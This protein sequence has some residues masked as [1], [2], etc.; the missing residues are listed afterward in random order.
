MKFKKTY[1]LILLLFF[2]SNIIAQNDFFIDVEASN[3][4]IKFLEKIETFSEEKLEEFTI[5]ENANVPLTI[6]EKKLHLDLKRKNKKLKLPSY[7]IYF[8]STYSY[9]TLTIL[10]ISRNYDKKLYSRTKLNDKTNLW[11][12]PL[13]EYQSM[14]S[15]KEY[16]NLVKIIYQLFNTHFLEHNLTTK[17]N[18]I[19][20][21][22]TKEYKLLAYSFDLFTCSEVPLFKNPYDI[23]SEVTEWSSVRK[24]IKQD[25]N[26]LNFPLPEKI[27][28]SLLIS[29]K[30][31]STN[32]NNYS[33]SNKLTSNL[34]LIIICDNIGLTYTRDTD[35]KTFWANK[36]Y[37]YNY[38]N[39]YQ[40]F[41][42]SMD[43]F[44]MFALYNTYKH[45]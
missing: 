10:G 28:F 22:L 16:F 4:Q 45:N 38:F 20:Y 3:N 29:Y 40:V 44:I 7:R 14:L 2:T 30:Q 12:V 11:V 17:F 8:N 24:F 13:V 34:K 36:N 32:T 9:D 43:F 5:F 25:N 39:D 27:D 35:T 6:A 37:V 26:N 15:R 1:K 18:S 31:D 23:Q 21:H 19:D 42:T 33:P 41:K